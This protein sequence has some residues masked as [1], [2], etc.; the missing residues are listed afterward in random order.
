MCWICS[1]E[2]GGRAVRPPFLIFPP[3]GVS[4]VPGIR[5][6]V[7]GTRFSVPG[8]RFSVPVPA[9]PKP[10]AKILAPGTEVAEG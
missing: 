6:S 10:F 2:K 7:P 9:F 8:I 5:F 4:A 1:K 3:I